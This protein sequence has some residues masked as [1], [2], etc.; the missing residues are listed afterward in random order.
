[1]RWWVFVLFTVLAVG[2]DNGFGSVFTLRGAWFLAPSFAGCLVAFIALSAPAPTVVWAG[3]FVGLLIDLSPGLGEAVGSL[4]VIGPHALG[5]ALGAWLVLTLR[6]YVFRRRVL[7]VAMLTFAVVWA[8]G[9]VQVLL[10]IVRFWLPWAGGEL[11]PFGIG[12]LLHA[13]GNAAY[14]A[15]LAIPVGWM[16]IQSISIWRFDYGTTR[17][18]Y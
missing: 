18:G 16:L 6:I 14:S 8:A 15:L 3:W 17:R 1:M 11:V 4:H 10:G 7:T 12:E 13:T 9:V 2:L 5:F